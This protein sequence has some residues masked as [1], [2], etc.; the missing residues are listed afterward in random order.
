MLRK[1]LTE[2][3]ELD[4]ASLVQNIYHSLENIEQQLQEEI[5]N[6]QALID[7]CAAETK[8][9]SHDGFGPVRD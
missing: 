3:F 7:R 8:T 4:P 6:K 2:K 1:I 9:I 5:I